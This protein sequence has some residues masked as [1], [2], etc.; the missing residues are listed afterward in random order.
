M[1]WSV[2]SDAANHSVHDIIGE[3]SHVRDGETV[4]IAGMLTGVSRRIAKSS[5]NQYASVELE[6]PSG[7]TITV[8]FSPRL[9]DD[10]R[11]PGGRPHLLDSWPRSAP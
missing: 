9:R 11:R 7:A 1:A 4:T 5:G 2:R 10:G 6:D 3:D 8:M